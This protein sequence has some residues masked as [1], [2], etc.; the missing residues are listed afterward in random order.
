MR[1]ATLKLQHFKNYND[2]V[3]DFHP[4]FNCLVGLNGMGKTN[5]L[6]AIHYLAF[7]KSAFSL[8]DQ[9]VLQHDAPFFAVHGTFHA[10]RPMDVSCYMESGKKKIIKINRSEPEKFSDHIGTI[11]LIF[12]SP[13]DTA[14]IQGAS[15]IRRKLVDGTLSQFDQGF[16]EDLLEYQKVLRQRNTLLKN[17]QSQ[18]QKALHGL[19]DIYDEQLINRSITI[20]KKRGQLIGKLTPLFEKNYQVL[21]DGAEQ[22][23]IQFMT[24]VLTDSF[25]NDFLE[26][27]KRDM[28]SQRTH[29]GCHRDDVDFLIGGY[30]VK[31]MGSQ[32]QQKSV[33]LALRLA[34][35]DYL[36]QQT[37][38]RPMIMLDDIFDKF[39]DERIGQLI[40]LLSD[41]DRFGQVVLTDARPGRVQQLFDNEQ[42]VRIF[43][44]AHGKKIK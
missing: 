10:E 40:M 42:A 1:I 33:I 23:E 30:S 20:S 4:R 36:S 38:T 34:Q 12:T 13:Y 43:S 15:E 7:T 26:G 31:K 6:D 39:D 19:L 35:F 41:D 25:R 14:I 17:Q 5:V 21:T 18:S 27:R 37:N 11:P 44:I 8:T 9:Q 32:G 29:S 2:E 24:K 22:T 28:I 16:L 3:F